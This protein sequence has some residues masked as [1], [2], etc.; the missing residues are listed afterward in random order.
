MLSY[1]LQLRFPP[2]ADADAFVDAPDDVQTPGSPHFSTPALA[3]SHALGS[4]LF[5]ACP[6]HYQNP[7]YCSPAPNA[8][9]S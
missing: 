7:V 1:P 5:C 9:Q 8:D 4:A 6:T 3:H 2:P